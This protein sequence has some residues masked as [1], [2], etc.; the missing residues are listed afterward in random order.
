M[1]DKIMRKNPFTGKNVDVTDENTDSQDRGYVFELIDGRKVILF[2]PGLNIHLGG[3]G[4]DKVHTYHQKNGSIG[5]ESSTTFKWSGRD[6]GVKED[7][8]GA[9]FGTKK[10]PKKLHFMDG[11]FEIKQIIGV[12]YTS[13]WSSDKYYKNPSEGTNSC[14]TGN[15]SEHLVEKIKGQFY[16]AS[17]ITLAEKAK[18]TT[19]LTVVIE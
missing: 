9:S 11:I 15:V 16:L 14:L 17:T 2:T 10:I 5:S 7:T 8:I 19:E 3:N 18:K 13:G 6:G 1:T 12:Y 4:A